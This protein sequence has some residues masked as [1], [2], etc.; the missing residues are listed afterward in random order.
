MVVCTYFS[1]IAHDYSELT[2]IIINGFMESFNLNT[3]SIKCNH[4]M[5]TQIHSEGGKGYVYV[6]RCTVVLIM[7]LV[8]PMFIHILMSMLHG[9]HAGTRLCHIFISITCLRIP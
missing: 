3:R 7:S 2:Q 6:K 9:V 1:I 5:C 4:G 8:S